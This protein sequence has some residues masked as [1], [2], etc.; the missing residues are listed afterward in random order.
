MSNV[1]QKSKNATGA[2]FEADRAV[3]VQRSIA[4]KKTLEPKDITVVIDTREQTPVDLMPL[5]AIRGTLR[6]GDY[7]VQGLTDVISVE[8][9]SLADLYGCI[10]RDRQRFQAEMQR[11]LAYPHRALVIEATKAEVALG[12]EKS[13]VSPNAAVGSLIGWAAMGIPIEYAGSHEGAGEFIK[14]FLFIAARR[15]WRENFALCD[16]VTKKREAG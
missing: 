11:L 5:E 15:R 2:E 12:Y 7:S 9:K 6:T 3:V 14:K 13:K 10:G 1:I 16:A 4:N 8:R